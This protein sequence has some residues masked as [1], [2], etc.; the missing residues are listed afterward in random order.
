MMFDRDYSRM[1]LIPN[2][3][4]QVFAQKLNVGR[5]FVPMKVAATIVK[6]FEVFADGE[7]VYKTDNNAYSLVLVPL[8]RAVKNVT[9]RCYD[10]WGAEKI[11][12]FGC[13]FV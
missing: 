13:D 8:K 4:M 10:T 2:M 7:S 5:D 12:V 6:S 9:V 1:S 11:H 3:K